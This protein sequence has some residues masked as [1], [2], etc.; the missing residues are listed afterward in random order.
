[1]SNIIEQIKQKIATD[2]FVDEVIDEISCDTRY[3]KYEYSPSCSQVEEFWGA[4][5][6]YTA[7]SELEDLDYDK[8]EILGFVCDLLGKTFTMDDSAK[9]FVYKDSNFMSKLYDKLGTDEYNDWWEELENFI[10][11]QVESDDDFIRD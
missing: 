11:E 9:E 4:P 1:M 8:S 10:I 7:P 5:C 6:V 3:W 2:E